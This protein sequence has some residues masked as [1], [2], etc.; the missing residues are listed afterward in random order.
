[1]ASQQAWMSTALRLD[2]SLICANW[3]Y[4]RDCDK[5]VISIQYTALSIFYFNKHLTFEKELCMIDLMKH[6]KHKMNVTYELFI[7]LEA[8]K[9]T[10]SKV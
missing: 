6:K 2:E 1:M 8:E 5:Y 10:E 4:Y 9:N 7:Y 3:M